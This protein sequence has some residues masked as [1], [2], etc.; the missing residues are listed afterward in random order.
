MSFPY[1]EHDVLVRHAFIIHLLCIRSAAELNLQENLSVGM[2][3]SEIGLLTNL[4]KLCLVWNG[5]FI[6]PPLVLSHSL[7]ASVCLTGELTLSNSGLTG[8]I[9][10]QIGLLTRLGGYHILFIAYPFIA[11]LLV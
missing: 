2:I 7:C 1:V 10:I 6:K 5:R 9:P 4:S 3:P 11:S 8:T